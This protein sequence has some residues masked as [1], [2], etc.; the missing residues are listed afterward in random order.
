VHTR[1]K[2][3]GFSASILDELRLVVEALEQYSDIGAAHS[4]G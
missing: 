2:E 3:L 1:L 4:G